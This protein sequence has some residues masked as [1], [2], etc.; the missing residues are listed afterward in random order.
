MLAELLRQTDA[1]AFVD[2]VRRREPR[3]FPGAAAGAPPLDM[4]GFE[5]MLGALH[6]AH[7]G[8]LH[9]ARGGDR[10]SLPPELVDGD[11]MLDL[12]QVRRVFES[13]ETLY[14]TKAHRLSPSLAD[15]CR[16]IELDLA[17]HGVAL[18]EPA[19]AHVFATPPAAQGFAPHRD[20][21]GSLVV[22]LEGHKTWRV[23]D[24]NGP[25]RPC[26]VPTEDWAR[27][28]Q[29][30]F[31]LEPGDVLYVPEYRGHAAR[32]G[33]VSSLHLT[34]R[35]FPLRWR[36]VLDEVVAALPGLNAPVPHARTADPDALAAGLTDLLGSP[37]VGTALPGL[38]GGLSARRT[39]R[40]AVLADGGLVEHGSLE[41]IDE[42][43]WLARARGTDCQVAADDVSATIHFPGGAVRG[44]IG[45][46]AAFEYV[47]GARVL[48]AVDLPGVLAPGATVD[49]VRRLVAEG[50]LRRARPTEIDGPVR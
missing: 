46:L 12:R 32:T 38:L 19:G 14:L 29:R 15:L 45:V 4:D 20:D 3:L 21:H 27:I 49:I 24:G 31:V 50:L 18:R 30:E 7:E 2:A 16:G 1:V 35:L 23:E 26:G 22:Q 9:L 48:R 47:A 28:P 40:R 39:A 44:P 25:Q 42:N 33:A 43:T 41:G 6:H 37:D 8:V 17:R 13:G 10:R 11:G 34:V 5:A 36:D